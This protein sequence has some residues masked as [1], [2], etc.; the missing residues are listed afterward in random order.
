MSCN[1]LIVD[2]SKVLRMAMRRVA[3]LAGVDPARIHEA[4]NGR[5]ALEVLERTWIDL[6]LLDLHM[7]VMDGEEFVRQLRQRPAFAD[8]PVIVVSTESN[9]ER[10]DRLRSLGVIESLRKPFEPEALSRHISHLLGVQP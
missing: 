10:L 8:T 9:S 2:D 6:V 7:P 5:E 3:E 4:S 1:L